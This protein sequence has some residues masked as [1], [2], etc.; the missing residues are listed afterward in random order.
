M[1]QG[2]RSTPADPTDIDTPGTGPEIIYTH[3]RT[4]RF[5]YKQR[6]R[7]ATRSVETH[8]IV[9]VACAV[10][11]DGMLMLSLMSLLVRML[12]MMLVLMLMCV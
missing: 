8:V 3:D 11:V 2:C 4:L 9:A 10:V 1:R 6:P 12:L 5:I 7:G